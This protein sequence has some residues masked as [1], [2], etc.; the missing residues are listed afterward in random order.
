M[1]KKYFLNYLFTIYPNTGLLII[2]IIIF[3]LCVVKNY[4]V[5]LYSF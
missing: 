3:V 5:S 1:V 4:F 2:Q